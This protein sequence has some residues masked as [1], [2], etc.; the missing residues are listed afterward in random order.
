MGSSKLGDPVPG[1]V[2]AGSSFSRE[3]HASR[4]QE[5]ACP[6]LTGLQI[7]I[8]DEEGL[9]LPLTRC[10]GCGSRLQERYLSPVM[11]FTQDLRPVV[12]LGLLPLILK[13]F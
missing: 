13:N 11:I 1:Q 9:C 2:Q 3:H 12:Y 7:L 8:S 5:P 4:V 10:P 6:L